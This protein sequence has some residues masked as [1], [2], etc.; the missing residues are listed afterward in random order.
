[1]EK[2]VAPLRKGC[3]YFDII[4]TNDLTTELSHIRDMTRNL[5][6]RPF[7]RAITE[8]DLS[9]KGKSKSRNNDAR[10][11]SMHLPILGNFGYA[12]FPPNRSFLV[13]PEKRKRK[14]DEDR[15]IVG[16]IRSYEVTNL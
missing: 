11:T 12:H 14:Y 5:K 13:K 15:S 8:T 2:G 9:S 16:S 10:V 1:M 4:S 3:T 6:F 7:N